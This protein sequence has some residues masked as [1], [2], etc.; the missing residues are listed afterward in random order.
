MPIEYCGYLGGFLHYHIKHVTIM[1]TDL[2]VNAARHDV[3]CG[4]VME[5]NS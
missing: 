4:Y 5:N 3:L 2:G 1:F